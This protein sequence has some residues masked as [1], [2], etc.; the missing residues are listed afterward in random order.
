MGMPFY[1]EG[2]ADGKDSKT[3][4]DVQQQYHPAADVDEVD[5][6]ALNG[7]ATIGR[8]T[9]AALGLGLGGVMVWEIG[10]DAP[11][12]ALLAAIGDRLPS[13]PSR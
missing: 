13:A 5:G 1:A 8:K 11:N 4:A 6:L 7:P 12:S 2:L 3:Y 9:Q 10:Q